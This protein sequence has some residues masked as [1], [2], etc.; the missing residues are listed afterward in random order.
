MNSIELLIS[1]GFDWKMVT[2][3]D[4]LYC[5]LFLKLLV[6]LLYSNA[7]CNCSFGSWIHHLFLAMYYA[8]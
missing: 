3:K 1:S 5:N 4:G 6:A 7:G 2:G 8:I